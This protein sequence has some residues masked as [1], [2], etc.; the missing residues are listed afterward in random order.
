MTLGDPP[1]SYG[2]YPGL[3]TVL[4]KRRVFVSYHHGGD[5]T[6]YN[7]F[8]AVY[9]EGYQLF[10]DRS[11]ERAY[12]SEDVEYVRWKIRSE[13]IKG[14]SCTIV[15]I[16]GQTHLRKFVDWELSATLDMQHGL[17]GI[18]LPTRQLSYDNKVIVPDR[19]FHDLQSGHAV[20]MNWENVNAATLK[21]N[22]EAAVARSAMLINNQA[23]L[24]QRNG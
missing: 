8:S 6:Y 12:D 9:S 4:T 20:M 16:G 11:L 7:T 23:P 24:R 17:L 21:T 22:I 18:V 5:Q 14:S 2:R 10:T 13:D 15:L 3:G 1:F 19:F